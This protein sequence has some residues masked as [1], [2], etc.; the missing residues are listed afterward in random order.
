MQESLDESQD[1]P[2]P[3]LLLSGLPGK[4]AEYKSV[5]FFF[6]LSHHSLLLSCL[7]RRLGVSDDF[8]RPVW[9]PNSSSPRW[10][11]LASLW[12]VR[13][14]AFGVQNPGANGPKLG[15]LWWL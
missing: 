5:F 13:V 2:L 8:L 3:P 7:I 9:Q 10:S 6:S 4:P 1:S 14:G 11:Q 12:F 15:P